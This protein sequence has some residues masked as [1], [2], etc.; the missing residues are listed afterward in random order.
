MLVILRLQNPV[1]GNK[2]EEI[3]DK[4]YNLAVYSAFRSLTGP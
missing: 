2:E 3:Q 1:E 4:L